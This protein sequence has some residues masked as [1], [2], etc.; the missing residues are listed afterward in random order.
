MAALIGL[1]HGD[2]DEVDRLIDEKFN[3]YESVPIRCLAQCSI[4]CLQS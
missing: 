3:R 1:E 2:V 4:L